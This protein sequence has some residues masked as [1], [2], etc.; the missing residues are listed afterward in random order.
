VAGGSAVAGNI[1]FI[2]NSFTYGEGSAVHFYR[3]ASVTNLNG[4]GNGAG[5]SVVRR[6][7]RNAS[8]HRFIWTTNSRSSASVP[9]TR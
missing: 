1:L 8:G 9:G 2:G 5:R 3:A 4:E 7:P 6:L